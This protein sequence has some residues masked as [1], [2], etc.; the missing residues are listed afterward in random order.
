MP[1]IALTIIAAL[2]SILGFILLA[3]A[4]A[5]HWAAVSKTPV[6]QRVNSAWLTSAGLGAQIAALILTI[7]AQG[8]SFGS[9][10]WTVMISVAAMAVTFTLAWR[11]KWLRPIALLLRD[12][13]PKTPGDV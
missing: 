12:R 6:E 9:L 11:P 8:S 1:D 3:L 13:T 5:R 2:V 10:L 7:Q 4:Q